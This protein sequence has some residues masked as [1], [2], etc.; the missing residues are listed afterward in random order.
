MRDLRIFWRGARSWLIEGLESRCLLSV[1]TEMSV[2]VSSQSSY[3]RQLV[4]S[5]QPHDMAFDPVRQQLLLVNDDTV[6]RYNPATGQLLGS[7][8][9]PGARGA[10]LTQDA[11]YLYVAGAPTGLWKVDLAAGTAAEVPVALATDQ[12]RTVDLALLGSN[13]VITSQE[14]FGTTH[15]QERIYQLSI[16]AGTTSE[17][18]SCVGQA[19]VARSADFSTVYIASQHDIYRCT[20]SGIVS[21]P[22]ARGAVRGLSVS[23]DGALVAISTEGALEIRDASL[24]TVR[25]YVVLAN[26]GVLFDAGRDVLYVSDA[27][28]D[29]LTAYD[30][31]TWR[32]LA[33][34]QA[35][36]GNGTPESYGNIMC[37]SD[38][39]SALFLNS[40]SEVRS[41]DPSLALF[42]YGAAMWLNADVRDA[43]NGLS[44]KSG[45]VDY[46]DA[47]TGQS[48]GNVGLYDGATPS[49]PEKGSLHAGAHTILAQYS[50][51]ADHAAATFSVTVR[52]TKV[53]A[54][55]SLVPPADRLT[56]RQSEMLTA[57]ASS[58]CGLL[59][60]GGK[61]TFKDGTRI[62][63]TA[64]MD[65]GTAYFKCPPLAHGMHSFHA[66]YSGGAD[67]LAAVSPAVTQRVVESSRVTLTTSRPST[68]YGQS[69]TFTA[70][71]TPADA[72][73][74]STVTLKNES[75][76]LQSLHLNKTGQA[77]FTVPLMS[78][79]AHTLSAV[80]SGG[81]FTLGST[82]AGVK[83]VVSKAAS[84]GTITA[85]VKTTPWGRKLQVGVAVRSSI[86]GGPVPVGDIVLYDGRRITGYGRLQ[87][88]RAMV[89]TL[90]LLSGGAHKVKVVYTGSGNYLS[91]VAGVMPVTVRPVASTLT[92]ASSADWMPAGGS[93]TLTAKLN[94]P[95]GVPVGSGTVT[96]KEG[97]KTLGT[98]LV[99]ASKAVLKL[100]L[101]SAGLHKITA[102]FAGT[103][104][105]L[106]SKSG[107]VSQRIV[108]MS[109]ID[110]MV[111]YTP[112]ARQSAEADHSTIGEWI[113]AAVQDANT[114][115]ANSLIAT[116]L[117]LVETAE[118]DYTDSGSFHTDLTRLA[119]PADGYMDN[120]H[121]LRDQYGADLVSLLV[122]DG[123]LGGVGYELSNLYSAD[124]ASLGFSVVLA[125]QASA[126][127][128]T[129]AHEIG[130]NLGAEHDSDNLTDGVSSPFAY[131]HGYRFTADGTSLYHDIMSYDPGA[132]IPYFA[133][134]RVLFEGVPTGTYEY[135][136]VA[137]VINQ[138]ASIVAAYRP[139]ATAAPRARVDEIG[140][141]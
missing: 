58:E 112:A 133:N 45:H 2:C 15:N 105:C 48:L 31:R 38:D 123:D 47:A 1:A 130:H 134:P 75:G 6:G 84:V 56:D 51:D 128:F 54:E 67:F 25:T 79:G 26:A 131:S 4:S 35:G 11:K 115:F 119:N 122:G 49:G 77:V 3:S 12:G 98:A 117:N 10:D 126:P 5:V 78:A 136:D 140:I 118:V 103:G 52:I 80:Y 27:W 7:I 121:A 34:T 86:P 65:H 42:S 28:T 17:A 60:H 96:F 93:A 108:P 101:L 57:A 110:L 39:G 18:L 20:E 66:E 129:L 138:T 69:L 91:A 46:V 137:R 59:P 92:L 61:V 81:G 100:G 36:D 76:V 21:S 37:M 72:G 83:Q 89:T 29:T 95:A 94:T 132:T 63:G 53:S 135:S 30:T 22:I 82:S 41:Y 32:Q 111:V 9:V 43:T 16:N 87:N 102:A 116:R 44:V 23:R 24:N 13:T 114:A 107:A 88:G 50:G 14:V 74:S 113:D 104:N 120:V 139:H 64:P 33:R 19:T 125:A 109:T 99:S 73:A 40:G 90:G 97:T 70:T 127:T 68:V 55:L 124:N 8:S 62:L 141:G 85:P 71:V 106:A